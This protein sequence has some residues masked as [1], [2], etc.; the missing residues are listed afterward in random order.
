[1]ESTKVIPET[2]AS[3]RDLDVCPT[4]AATLSAAA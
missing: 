3:H 4:G 1:M 2:G